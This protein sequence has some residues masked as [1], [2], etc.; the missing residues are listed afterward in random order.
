MQRRTQDNNSPRQALERKVAARDE[1]AAR[2]SAPR[3]FKNRPIG[4]REKATSP[5]AQRG[6]TEPASAEKEP[7]S[8]KGI[9]GET[10]ST[11]KE[12]IDQLVK[13]IEERWEAK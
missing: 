5:M 11:S 4:H 6:V 8:V 12:Q 1:N 10:P 7:T 9:A 3:K 2:A 13:L